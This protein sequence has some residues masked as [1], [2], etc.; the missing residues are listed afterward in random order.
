MVSMEKTGCWFSRAPD[1][2]AYWANAFHE[3]WYTT[4]LREVVA[5]HDW[6]ARAGEAELRCGSCR[7]KRHVVHRR[8]R[9]EGC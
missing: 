6:E 7:L 5:F 9:P 4:D 2:R 3:V 1:A 8:K